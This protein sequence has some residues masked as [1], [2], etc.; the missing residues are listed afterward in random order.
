MPSPDAQ[1]LSQFLN[2]PPE[3]YISGSALAKDLS[4]SRVAIK[5]HIDKLKLEGF[6]FEASTHIGYRLIKKPTQLCAPL[7]E[8]YLLSLQSQN[9]PIHF[10]E[11][12][13]STMDA[14]KQLIAKNAPTPFAII[15][16]IQTKGR[17]RLGR[18][19]DSTDTGNLYLTLTFQPD[20]PPTRME[21]FSLWLAAS[22][23]QLYHTTFKAPIQAK[24]PND[25]LYKGKKLAGIL[26]EAQIDS[27]LMRYLAI[28]MGINLNTDL[29]K[30]PTALQK[31]ATS[32]EQ[33]NGSTI[34]MSWAAA[35]IIHTVNKAY[36]QFLKPNTIDKLPKLWNQFDYLKDKEIQVQ[37]FDQSYTG[38]A[39]GITP[40]GQL[41]LKIPGQKSPLTFNSG[42][43]SLSE[44]YN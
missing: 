20:L 39:Q 30:L 36:T 19:W 35:N 31:K 16:R 7:I 38:K 32:L 10:F 29:Q 9:I 41:Q 15:G 27:D 18:S 33:I 5:K 4:I 25:L 13:P 21:G 1:L 11:E 23:C 24:W 3:D 40:T 43:V 28:G 22:L 14:A 44:N 8:A 6:K 37:T 26:V 17:G 2:N 34:D 42:D 12:T